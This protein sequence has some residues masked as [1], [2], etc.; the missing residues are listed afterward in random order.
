MFE[1][2]LAGVSFTENIGQISILS[3]TRRGATL[4]HIEEFRRASDSPVWFLQPLLQRDEKVYRKVKRVSVAVDHAR[5][6]FHVFPVDSELQDP[7]RKDQ[8][9]WELAQFVPEGTAA[10]YVA[11]HHVLLNNS[12][13]GTQEVLMIA[14]RREFVLAIQ[15]ELNRNK[16][17]CGL[18]D[19]AYFGAE[20]SGVYS[21]SEIKNKQI[22]LI[23]CFGVRA[24]IGILYNGRLIHYRFIETPTNG[25]IIAALE[26]IMQQWPV[27]EIAFYGQ[28]LSNRLIQEV[29]E[30][31][32]KSS[33]A[34]NAL[35]GIQSVVDRR[36][37][38]QY[39]GREHVLAPS[40]GIA[41]R[42]A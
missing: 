27:E 18:I 34:I 5:L 35:K 12:Q 6:L 29:S 11:D 32:G 13:T 25:D 36:L 2:Y 9:A 39:V 30:Q 7:G 33:F 40:I 24:D 10:D 31:F 1:K 28:S 41:L 3:L 14:A 17:D 4:H 26:V 42:K 38:Q 21:H 8:Y 20:S 19:A 23:G 15:N 22:A 37:L 16:F